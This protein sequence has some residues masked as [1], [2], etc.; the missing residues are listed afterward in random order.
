MLYAWYGAVRTIILNSNVFQQGNV[1]GIE[2]QDQAL[3]VYLV[4]LPGLVGSSQLLNLDY[5]LLS[6]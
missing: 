6:S 4:Y 1:P 2:F 3:L 5:I